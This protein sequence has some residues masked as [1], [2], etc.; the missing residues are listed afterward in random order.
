MARKET[1]KKTGTGAGRGQAAKGR[2]AK[3]EPSRGGTA[4]ISHEEIAKRAREIWEQRGRP[5]GEDEK[6]WLE[7]EEQLTHEPAVR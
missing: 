5:A 2:G 4:T 1:Q 3:P 6:I 7:A